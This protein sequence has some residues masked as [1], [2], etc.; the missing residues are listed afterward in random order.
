MAP[1]RLTN[2]GTAMHNP[3]VGASI[4]HANGMPLLHFWLSQHLRGTCTGDRK[5]V[6]RIGLQATADEVETFIESA[7]AAASVMCLGNGLAE[8]L[9]DRAVR[10]QVLRRSSSSSPYRPYPT[11]GLCAE[12][13]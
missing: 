5:A 3:A 12:A 10:Q 6:V 4:C 13:G 7:M 1:T 8:W 11:A 2:P 9:R